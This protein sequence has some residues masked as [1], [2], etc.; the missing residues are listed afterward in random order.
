MTRCLCE[1]GWRAT[2]KVCSQV[3]SDSEVPGQCEIPYHRLATNCSHLQEQVVVSKYCCSCLRMTRNS[4]T[5][6]QTS[7][8]NP[9]TRELEHAGRFERVC[10]IRGFPVPRAAAKFRVHGL[11]ALLR[12]VELFMHSIPQ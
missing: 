8:H 1:E 7:V 6:R 2:A 10:R 4:S 9:P 5:H 11:N 12:A 3:A